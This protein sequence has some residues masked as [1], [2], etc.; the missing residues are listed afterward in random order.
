LRATDDQQ[1][2]VLMQAVELDGLEQRP[3]RRLGLLVG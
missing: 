1:E 3:G 2:E